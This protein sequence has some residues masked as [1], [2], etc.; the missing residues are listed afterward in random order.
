VTAAAARTTNSL[1]RRAEGDTS[2]GDERQQV[3]P[4]GKP[5]P[6][7]AHFFG[8]LGDDYALYEDLEGVS[9]QHHERSPEVTAVH[10]RWDSPSIVTPCALE[11]GDPSAADRLRYRTQCFCLVPPG[12]RRIRDGLPSL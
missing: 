8:M 7:L 4:A 6:E 11:S 5:F 9:G 2:L 12:K 1:R 3:V 10:A